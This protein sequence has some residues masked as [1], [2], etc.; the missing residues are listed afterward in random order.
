MHTTLIESGNDVV[1]FN[2]T[3]IT[4]AELDN[5]LNLFFS[6]E[7][8]PLR[9]DKPEE[10]VFQRGNKV[11][12]I[13]FGAFVKYF[14]IVVTIRKSGDLFSVRLLRDMNLAVSGGLIGINKS[15]KEFARLT[16][17]FKEYFK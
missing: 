9:S 13:L 14:K 8:L 10:K 3:G 17:A 4:D 6:A 16:E 5:K 12:R 15:R 1:V 2:I 7:K 11:M